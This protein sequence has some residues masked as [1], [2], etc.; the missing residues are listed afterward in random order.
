MTGTSGWG[1]KSCP[2]DKGELTRSSLLPLLSPI[3]PAQAQKMRQEQGRHI[4]QHLPK[5]PF[6]AAL[7]AQLALSRDA[8]TS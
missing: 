1:G 4:P 8:E 3:N 2:E 7:A 6:S 5:Y